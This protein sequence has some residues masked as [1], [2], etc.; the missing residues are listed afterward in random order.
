MQRD[1]MLAILAMDTY[2]RGYAPGVLAI[3]GSSVGEAALLADS[4]ILDEADN[5]DVAQAIG[6]YAQ[7]YQYQGETIIAFRGTDDI[8]TTSFACIIV[9][10]LGTPFPEITGPIL[11]PGSPDLAYGFGTGAGH[12]L[13][14]Q[15]EM[16]LRFYQSVSGDTDGSTLATSNISLTG[17][18]L[19]GGLADYV[20]ALYNNAA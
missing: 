11:G 7:A 16:A 13:S 5:R 4:A 6:F 1:L 14:S 2:H 15:A 17:H 8:T 9:D 12:P 20:A 18:S 3:G 19:G 10:I